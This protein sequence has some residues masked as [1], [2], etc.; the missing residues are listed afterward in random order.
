MCQTR[1]CL[2]HLWLRKQATGLG[3]LSEELEALAQ[4]AA[5]PPEQTDE[6]R[7]ALARIAEKQR[8]WEAWR[9]EQ[10]ALDRAALQSDAHSRRALRT[11]ESKAGDPPPRTPE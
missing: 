4:R 10:A 11:A 3:G 2:A 7:D 6:E 9:R 1:H 5:D 8:A